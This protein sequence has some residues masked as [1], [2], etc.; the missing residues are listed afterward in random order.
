M[1]RCHYH[2]HCWTYLQNAVWHHRSLLIN[3]YSHWRTHLHCQPLHCYCCIYC[4]C[5]PNHFPPLHLPKRFQSQMHLMTILNPVRAAA[6]FHLG[7]LGHQIS[8]VQLSRTCAAGCA[9]HRTPSPAV[10][11]L[12][13]S[14]ERGQQLAAVSLTRSPARLARCDRRERGVLPASVYFTRL[15]ARSLACLPLVF[16]GVIPSPPLSLLCATDACP[17]FS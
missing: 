2:Y 9:A 6:H 1:I 17:L 16:A 14:R 11:A 12:C 13:D 10:R 8:G 3:Q 7:G 15:L 5:C 4:C